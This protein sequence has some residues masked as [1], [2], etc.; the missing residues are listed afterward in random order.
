MDRLE[1]LKQVKD[2]GFK[3]IRISLT[4]DCNGACSFCHNEGQ[5]IGKRGDNASPTIPLLS[6][7]DYEYIAKFFRT[8]L[9][10]VSFTGGEPTLVSNLPE[11][12]KIFKENGY[13]TSMTTNGFLLD[14]TLQ[15]KLANVGL[16][17][18][19]VSVPSLDE[20]EYSNMYGVQHKLSTVLQ[21]LES[22]SQIFKDKCKIN[23]MALLNRNTPSQLIPMSNLSGKLG[24][25]ISFLTVLNNNTDYMSSYVLSYL[26][27]NIGIKNTEIKD[28]KFGTKTIYTLNNGA[29][30]EFDDFREEQ[31]REKAFD[32]EECRQ[33]PSRKVCVE[34]P[35]ALRISSDGTIRKC[36]IRKNNLIPLTKNGYCHEK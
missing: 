10:S 34:G 16:D 36:L 2:M 11:I 31:Y 32:N 15:E 29:K 21:N 20:K 28:G 9:S 30:W 35:Y 4:Q 18:I 22:L 7:K 27:D 24:I 33:C 26:K 12:V 14:K 17:K 5:K 8:T 1:L 3:Y 6:L 25:P 19:N 23:Y 13:K